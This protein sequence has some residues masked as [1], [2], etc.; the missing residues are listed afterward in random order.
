MNAN[1]KHK[2]QQRLLADAEKRT[3]KSL[4]WR[5]FIYNKAKNVYAIE[6]LTAYFSV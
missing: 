4:F 2:V 5:T 6:A 3:K 1:W